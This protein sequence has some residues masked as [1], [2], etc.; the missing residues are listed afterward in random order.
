MNRII[1]IFV[2]L[3]IISS[4]TY[5]ANLD[6]LLDVQKKRAGEYGASLF[7]PLLPSNPERLTVSEKEDYRFLL[8]YLPLSD[9][10]SITAQQLISN[11]RL[12]QQARRDFLWG[13]QLDNILYQHFV[14]PHRISQEPYVHGWRDQFLKELTPRIQHMSMSEAALEVNQWCLEYATFV[15]TDSRDQDIFTTIRSGFGRCEEEMIFTIAA[16]RSVGIPARQCY[17]PYWA[18]GDNNHAWVEMWTDGEWRYYGACEPEPALDQGW[19]TENAART[20][21]VI[22]SAYGDYAGKEPVYKR[23][24]YSTSINSTAVYGKTRNLKIRVVRSDDD[25]LKKKNVVFSII[26]YGGLMPVASLVTDDKGYVE[27]TCGL[28]DCWVSANHK[29]TYALQFIKG[30]DTDVTLV[31]NSKELVFTN[32]NLRYTPPPKPEE[33]TKIEKDSL[34]QCKTT[35]A[36]SLRKLRLW[37]TWAREQKV[38]LGENDPQKPDSIFF[39]TYFKEDEK[40]REEFESLKTLLSQS[41]GNW[42]T[43][44]R[45]VFGFYPLHNE[46]RRVS[47]SALAKVYLPPLEEPLLLLGSLSDKDLRDFS[48]AMLQDHK[49]RIEALSEWK[50]YSPKGSKPDSSEARRIQETVVCPRIDNEPSSEWRSEFEHLLRTRKDLRE[51]GK[52]EKWLKSNFEI[53]KNPDRLGAPLTPIQILKLKRVTE[54][55]LERLYIAIKRTNFESARF[56]PVDDR[57]ELWEKGEWKTITLFPKDEESKRVHNGAV[58]LKVAP[59]SVSQNAKYFQ[60]WMIQ[61]W[62]DD[63]GQPMQYGFHQPARDFTKPLILSEGTYLFSYGLRNKDGS[64]P[65]TLQWF[66]VKRKEPVELLL[67]LSSSISGVE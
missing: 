65:V 32:S 35:S 50:T 1:R 36:D 63:R 3:T 45:F 37:T 51:S 49:V 13:S 48:S 58:T 40:Q 61:K 30:T 11:I 21:L 29:E 54:T 39:S 62:L 56:N 52:L 46:F 19:F 67:D 34:F 16:L 38:A 15:Q 12:A 22:S 8:A 23:F 25:P 26:N 57:L 6:S 53:E 66:E 24:T 42:G 4:I 60:E 33:F 27:L 17:T 10:A 5:S 2:L 9:L 41:K 20:F 44:F 14:L 7:A 28:G 43:I 59:D 47:K 18:T 31:V 64:V 55:D